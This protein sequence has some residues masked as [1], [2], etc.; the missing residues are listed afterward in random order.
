[1]RTNNITYFKNEVTVFKNGTYIGDLNDGKR[2]G[3]G[4]MLSDSGIIY[5]G[6]SLYIIL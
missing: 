3:F 5:I 1:M 6:N 2:N 4:V